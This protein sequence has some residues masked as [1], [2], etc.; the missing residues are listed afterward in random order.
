MCGTEQFKH[1][2]IKNKVEDWVEGARHQVTSHLHKTWS[3]SSIL[4]FHQRNMVQMDTFLTTVTSTS[5]L[6]EP[7]E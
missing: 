1:Q 2:L 4:N 6:F 3:S 5:E 7:L